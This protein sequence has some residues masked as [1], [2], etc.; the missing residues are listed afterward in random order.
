MVDF[1]QT[2]QDFCDRERRE[3]LGITI[4]QSVGGSTIPLY[5][6]EKVANFV[7]GERRY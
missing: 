3:A 4:Q 1:A 2:V 7:A 6:S 5:I